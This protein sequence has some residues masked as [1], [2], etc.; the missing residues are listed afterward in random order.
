MEKITSNKE[1]EVKNLVKKLLIIHTYEYSH[2]Y[3]YY[4]FD[5]KFYPFIHTQHKPTIKM[6]NLFIAIVTAEFYIY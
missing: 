5:M 1:Q 2:Y 4:K 6:F 3:Y